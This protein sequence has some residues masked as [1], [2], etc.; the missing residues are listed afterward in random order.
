[1]AEDVERGPEI[2]DAHQELVRHIEQGASKMRALSIITVVVAAVLAA[3]YLSQLA[4]TFTGTK[5]VT[6]TLTDPVN[7]AAEL[8]VLAL[9]LVWLYV[10]VRDLRFS[11]RIKR[12][13]RAARTKEEG[14]KK[15]VS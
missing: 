1:M 9:T 3:S 15:E 13:I 8:V 5:T 10:G 2:L 11:W 6:V 14:I 7:I 4:L 12:E